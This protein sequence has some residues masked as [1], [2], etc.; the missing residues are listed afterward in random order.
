MPETVSQER[1]EAA[2]EKGFWAFEGND[3]QAFQR[4]L[5]TEGAVVG[6]KAQLLLSVAHAKADVAEDAANPGWVAVVNFVAPGRHREIARS[7]HEDDFE[8]TI[9]H[10]LHLL[11]DER[12]IDR[13]WKSLTAQDA[14]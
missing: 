2:A 4:V 5:R 1:A 6:K 10:G 13:L 11:G 12:E 3:G 7:P 8:T 14:N 9:E